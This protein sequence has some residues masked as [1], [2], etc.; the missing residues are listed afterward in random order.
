VEIEIVKTVGDLVFFR[1]EV[2]GSKEIAAEGP[3]ADAAL[4]EL[5]MRYPERFGVTSVRV[6]SHVGQREAKRA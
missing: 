6:I 2:I 1:A 3:T 5:V 4:G